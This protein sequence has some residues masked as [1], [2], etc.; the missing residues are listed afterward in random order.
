MTSEEWRSLDLEL[1]RAQLEVTVRAAALQ[2][3]VTGASL[4]AV[5]TVEDIFDVAQD[6]EM[7]LRATRVHA[8]PVDGGLYE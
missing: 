4:P 6:M 1:R 5:R 7:Y 3:A 2:A 8:G